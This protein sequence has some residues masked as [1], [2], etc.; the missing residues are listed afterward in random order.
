M[1]VFRL[2]PCGEEGCRICN[3][4]WKSCKPID[5]VLDDSP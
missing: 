2:N 3:S 5:L 1:N 4:C